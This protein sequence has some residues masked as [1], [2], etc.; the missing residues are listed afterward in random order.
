MKTIKKEQ[1]FTNKAYLINY[2]TVEK[3][4]KQLLN[5]KGEKIKL[6]EK[7][8]KIE[9]EINNYQKTIQFWIKQNKEIEDKVFQFNIQIYKLKEQKINKIKFFFIN[10]FS[11]GK[12]NKNRSINNLIETEEINCELF[13]KTK[14]NNQQKINILNSNYIEKQT[15]Y[16]NLITNINQI[17]EYENK[18]LEDKNNL[19]NNNN[20]LLIDLINQKEQQEKET[21]V[22]VNEQMVE[23]F[24]S[25]I[26]QLTEKIC[27]LEKQL[28]S[29][30][31]DEGFNSK[32][33]STDSLNSDISVPLKIQTKPQISNPINKQK[34]KDIPR[35]QTL[36]KYENDISTK[37]YKQRIK[38]T[39]SR[40]IKF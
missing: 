23:Q 26:F 4:K 31:S 34:E 32:S 18:L 16:A 9:K 36:R 7:S 12:I 40:I 13:K 5:L 17:T 24:E 29:N 39:N 19:L 22:E 1:I 25:E 3:I 21:I 37:N 15:K 30:S 33:T 35:E 38:P 8:E 27:D 2:E 10:L 14:L 11:F 28:L 20:N 6:I